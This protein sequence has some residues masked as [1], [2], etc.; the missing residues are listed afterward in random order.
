MSNPI[1]P[2]D[3]FDRTPPH[4]LEAE[5]SVLGAMLL[6]PDDAVGP[7]IEILGEKNIGELFYADAHRW[8][9]KAILGMYQKSVPIDPTTMVEELTK[10]DKFDAIGGMAYLG[11]LFNAVPTSANVE[12]YA[13]IVL[14]NALLRRLPHNRPSCFIVANDTDQS[15]ADGQPRQVLGDIAGNT[16]TT[17]VAHRRVRGPEDRRITQEQRSI[18]RNATNTANGLIVCQ[19]D[20]IAPVR[21]SNFQ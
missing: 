16:A 6:N 19:H 8:I 7:T 14:D 4:S 2:G 1:A 5:R 10:M 12:Y 11:D 17:L 3:V 9:Y 21:F 18:Q 15:A 13:K 20:S